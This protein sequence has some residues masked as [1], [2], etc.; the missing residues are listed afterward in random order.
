[1]D[2]GAASRAIG[3]FCNS[4]HHLCLKTVFTALKLAENS[5]KYFNITIFFK[6]WQFNH[7]LAP[8][9]ICHMLHWKTFLTIS[10]NTNARR[11]QK[12][13][14]SNCLVNYE[15]LEVQPRLLKI[16][17]FLLFHELGKA[18]KYTQPKANI[19]KSKF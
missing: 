1:M 2:L 4:Y 9:L 12:W 3:K 11:L 5:Y 18:W 19:S 6:N 10:Q 16:S 17:V 14:F 15:K 13:Q 8:V 7:Q